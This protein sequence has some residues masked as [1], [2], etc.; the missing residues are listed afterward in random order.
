M[1]PYFFCII[2]CLHMCTINDNHMM[3]GSWDTKH[4]GQN[5]LS[6]WTFF[7]PSTPLTTQKMK[8]LKKWRNSLEIND[9]HMMY[10]SWN[11][12]RER[13]NFLSFW[14]I[15]CSFTQLT[16]WK[17]KILKKIF[18]TG[19]PKL[20]IICYTVPEIWHVMDIIVI[21]HFGLFFALLPPWKIKWKKKKMK[22]T[23]GD[24]IILQ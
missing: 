15:S 24:I 2:P 22:K 5:F 18:Y 10:G 11:M 14:L 6:F 13:Q 8:I 23:S 16:T 19:V 12:K 17:I 20:M 3:Y 7:C 21:F 4:D 9:S 1:R